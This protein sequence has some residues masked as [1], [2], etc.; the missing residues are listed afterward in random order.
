MAIAAVVLS[1]AAENDRVKFGGHGDAIF[2]F[3]FVRF[4]RAWQIGV[5]LTVVFGDEKL[6]DLEHLGSKDLA[7]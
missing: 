6:V 7:S 4:L 2:G 5:R 1:M 3:V